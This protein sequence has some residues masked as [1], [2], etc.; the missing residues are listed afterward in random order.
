MVKTRAQQPAARELSEYELE[1][2]ERIRQNEE[3]LASLGLVGQSLARP[4]RRVAKRKRVT[5][6]KTELRRSSRLAKEGSAEEAPPAAREEEEEEEEEDDEEQLASIAAALA[7]D[8]EEA[9]ETSYE[10]SVQSM[11]LASRDVAKMSRGGKGTALAFHQRLLVVASGDSSGR[12][13]VWDVE[14]DAPPFELARR[15][16]RAIA[17]VA[18]QDDSL[19]SAGYEGS[20]R[21]LDFGAGRSVELFGHDELSHSAFAD[22]SMIYSAHGDG[23]LSLVDARAG[24]RQWSFRAHDAKAAHVAPRPDGTHLASAGND[25]AV[26]LW[27]LRALGK[28]PVWLAE[29]ERSVRGC[30][31]TRDGDA[32][33][34]LSYDNSVRIYDESALASPRAAETRCVAIFHDNT[35]GRFLTP[36]KPI[37]DPHAPY[38]VVV[39]GS[40][41]RP[42]RLDLLT[43]P[44]R[45]SRGVNTVNSAPNRCP[46]TTP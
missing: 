16:G 29:H 25:A 13:A 3:Y 22:S 1:R 5:A 11:R 34:S 35:T 12:L 38:P 6:E 46:P 18:W 43:A 7:R 45:A 21:R 27:D 31:W 4:A 10:A 32:L 33:C 24:Q 39:L 26:K 42:R 37:F 19:L 44:P 28:K 15:H 14:G 20:V 41:Q 23:T 2:L 40:L 36:F 8:A 9:D 30:A 17:A